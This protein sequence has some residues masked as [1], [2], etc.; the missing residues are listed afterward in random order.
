MFCKNCGAMLQEGANVCTQC[1]APVGAGNQYC[2]NC[3]QCSDGAPFCSNCGAPQNASGR[4][5]Q[6]TPP[7]GMPYGQPKSKLAAVIL[8]FLLGTLGI[9]NFY[10]G[11]T[12]KGIAQL[13]LTLIGGW[14]CGA[15]A[16]VAGIWAL[17][18]AVQLLTGSIDRDANGV[19]L[20]NEF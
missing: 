2:F 13:L 4:P 16:I 20:K 1:G 9:H 11:Y 8:A 7:G 3:G 6:Q 18:E 12:N 10:L 19:P 15:G 5:G 14:L 17:V